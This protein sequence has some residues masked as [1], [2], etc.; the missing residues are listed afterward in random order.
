MIDAEELKARVNYRDYLIARLGEGRREGRGM[1][2]SSPFRID[3]DPSFK[4][5]DGH[6][7][8]KDYG[9]GEA[10]DVYAFIEKLDGVGFKEAVQSLYE[11]VGSSPVTRTIKPQAKSTAP[12]Y[13]TVTW[14]DVNKATAHY[15]YVRSYIEFQRRI[16]GKVAHTA[17]LG[18]MTWSKVISFNGKTERIPVNRATFPYYFGNSVHGIESRRDDLTTMERLETEFNG[19]T[20]A[21]RHKIWHAHPERDLRSIG[22]KDILDAIHD[23]LW[24]PEEYRGKM[25]GALRRWSM[26]GRRSIFNI[27]PFCRIENGVYKWN[28]NVIIVHESLTDTLACQS[29]TPEGVANITYKPDNQLNIPFW[30]VLGEQPLLVYLA[31]QADEASRGYARKIAERLSYSKEMYGK[32]NY[33]VQFL[34]TPEGEYGGKDFGEMQ[35]KGLLKDFF[36]KHPIGVRD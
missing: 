30:K 16:S 6:E 2:W 3:N 12:S 32:S 35:E 15:P 7:Y 36:R 19:I 25:N 20:E 24:T 14:D 33:I 22:N 26:S 17:H 13:A 9:T 1:K 28:V 21:T 27:D 10:F 18:G 11:W 29:V 31:V 34:Y 4:H 23:D 5:G 8:A